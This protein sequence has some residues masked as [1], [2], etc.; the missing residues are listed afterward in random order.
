MLT[1]QWSFNAVDAVVEQKGGAVTFRTFKRGNSVVLQVIDT[2]VGMSEEVRLRC[3]EPFFSTKSEHG[4]G[5]GLRHRV[6]HLSAGMGEKIDIESEPGRGT[7]VT[8]VTAADPQ[9]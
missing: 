4:T 5:L 8:M 2:G 6:R 1:K 7:T 3:L 9:R